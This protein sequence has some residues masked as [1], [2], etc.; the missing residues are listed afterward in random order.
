MRE[1][2]HVKDWNR[3]SP[4]F[5]RAP[6]PPILGIYNNPVLINPGPA[7]PIVQFIFLEMRENKNTPAVSGLVQHRH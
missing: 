1:A 5:G 2:E 6:F 3:V 7:S 4:A